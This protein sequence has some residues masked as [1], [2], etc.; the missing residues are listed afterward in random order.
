MRRGSVTVRG[1]GKR[2]QIGSDRA[3][4][5]S[6]RESVS[7]VVGAPLRRLAHPGSS[8]GRI[9]TVWALRD[10]TFDVAPGDVVGLVGRNGAGK[11]TLLRILSRITTP[12]EGDAA[13]YGT[14]GSLL[15]VGTGFHP[16]LTGRENVYLNG[17]ILGMS[18]ADVKRQFEAIVE[19]AEISRYLDTPVKRYSSGMY[20][21]LAFA[22]AAH[23]DSDI[24]AIDE[25]FGRRRLRLSEE[26]SRQGRRRG[27]RRSHRAV[28]EPQHGHRLGFVRAWHPARRG[29]GGR[30]GADRRHRGD[31][32]RQWPDAV[33]RGRLAR[34]GERSRH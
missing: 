9:D 19:F 4:Y 6:L 25:V 16:E 21:R 28:R 10:V 15:K 20:V 5:G 14:I 23:L 3:Q 32:H 17:A 34:P 13:L 29:K 24:L 12:S 7:T 31:L 22:V 18:R 26:V 30:R 8:T 33:G 27:P 2:Y 11:S 1:L